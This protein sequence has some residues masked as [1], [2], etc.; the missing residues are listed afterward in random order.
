[1]NKKENKE[2]RQKLF[3]VFLIAGIVLAASLQILWIP[4]AQQRILEFAES[5]LGRSLARPEKWIGIMKQFAVCFPLL[6]LTFP[7][8]FYEFKIPVSSHK[9]EINP[10]IFGHTWGGVIKNFT[11]FL[12][13]HSMLCLFTVLTTLAVYGIRLFSLNIGIDTNLAFFNDILN[14]QEIG[15][16]GLVILKMFRP[17]GLNLYFQN[18]LAFAFLSTGTLFWAYFI[19]LF[20]SEKNRSSFFIFVAIFVSSQVWVESLY[21]TCMNA[22]TTFLVMACPFVALLMFSGVFE[23]DKKNIIASVIALVFMIAMYQ[24]V[25]VMFFCALM[26]CFAGYAGQENHSKKCCVINGAKVALLLLISLLIYFALDKFFVAV[27][28]RTQKSDYLTNMASKSFLGIILSPAKYVLSI[29]QINPVGFFFFC[30]FPIC[31]GIVVTMKKG[32]VHLLAFLAVLASVFALPVVGGGFVPLRAQYTLPVTEAFFIWF[33]LENT[34]GKFRKF[35]LTVCSI[36]A[37]LQIERSS[38]INYTDELRFLQDKN[39]ALNIAQAVQKTGADEETPIFIYG[40]FSPVYTENSLI[41]DVPGHS[42]FEWGVK[43]SPLDATSAVSFINCLGFHFRAVSG[44]DKDL[45]QKA[46]N[47]ASSMP[48]FPAENS[49][50][51]LGDVVV[52]RLSES[53]FEI[54]DGN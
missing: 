6:L 52:I 41:G 9:Q 49:V 4:N 38:M 23:N 37:L 31:I 43:K 15:R 18:F 24:A 45:I 13:N 39:T 8:C 50:R 47:E 17:F 1:M 5:M 16:F 30:V 36:A 20:F 33:A 19:S 7:F 46:R 12:K 3:F 53:S 22:E 54:N 21:F 40:K 28:F 26:I 32:I 25:I 44:N 29:F 42:I 27:V 48:D 11:H 35:L 2:S 10:K 34:G 51:N 14:W